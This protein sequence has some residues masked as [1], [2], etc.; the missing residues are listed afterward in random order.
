MRNLNRTKEKR[1]IS[2][3]HCTNLKELFMMRKIKQKQK[4]K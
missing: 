4:Q 3:T 1:K 2:K